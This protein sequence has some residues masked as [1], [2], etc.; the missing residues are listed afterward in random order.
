MLR[1][2]R[3]GYRPPSRPCA[4][5]AIAGIGPAVPRFLMRPQTKRSIGLPEILSHGNDLT[6]AND[7][8]LTER[9]EFLTELHQACSNESPVAGGRIVLTPPRWLEDVNGKD[10]PPSAGIQQWIVIGGPQ[11]PFEPD[12]LNSHGT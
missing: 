3:P 5:L 4:Y 7:Q 1:K 12:N 11:I 2:F 9:R 10:R 8:R 6:D